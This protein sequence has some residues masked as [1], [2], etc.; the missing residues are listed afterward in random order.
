[1][2]E[3]KKLK[4]NIKK[5]YLYKILMGM[6][7]SVPILVLFWQENGLNLTEIMLLQSFFALLTVILEIPSGYFADIYGRKNTLL[8]AGFMGY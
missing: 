7:F 8:I 4:Q 2:I 1:M 5:F 6:F 3:N